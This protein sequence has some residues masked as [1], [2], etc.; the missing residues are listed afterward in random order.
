V[1]KFSAQG[2]HFEETSRAECLRADLR[3]LG[4]PESSVPDC[5]MPIP[6]LA[7]EAGAVGATY[8]VEGSALGGVIMARTI[9]APS[10]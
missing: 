9:E 2:P 10:A 4:A 6:E 7:T 8:V 5:S 1:L 3:V